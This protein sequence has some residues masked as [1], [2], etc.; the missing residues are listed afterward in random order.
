MNLQD[1]LRSARDAGDSQVTELRHMM[2]GMK[3]HH[4]F[5]RKSLREALQQVSVTKLA[6]HSSV[7]SFIL[8]L[9]FSLFC[10]ARMSAR[11]HA[12]VVHAHTYTH[13]HTFAHTHIHAHACTH[14]HMHGHTHTHTCTHTCINTDTH[15]HTYCTH[16]LHN[17][18]TQY[19]T[20]PLI[21][22]QYF[23]QQ[24]YSFTYY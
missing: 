4:E 3:A 13:T 7:S 14:T 1:Q 2:E 15:T 16:R 5:E 19:P 10:C 12:D 20:S 8:D 23:G 11:T 22:K 6:F 24:K 17:N 21:Y 18:V 9:C